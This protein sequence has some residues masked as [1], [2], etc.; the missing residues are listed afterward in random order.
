M[1]NQCSHGT[2]SHEAH[3]T[4]SH[5]GEFCHC[6]SCCKR[7]EE[8]EC[9]FEKAK[10][11]WLCAFHQAMKEVQVDIMKSKI[12]NA[13]GASFEKSADAVMEAMDLKWKASMSKEKAKSD[14]KTKLA[15][16]MTSK[17]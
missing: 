6:S 14:L 11:M 7:H 9:P 3:H 5:H 4:D 16:I 8:A 13:M 12:K 17:P 10:G 2:C 1:E 15:Q